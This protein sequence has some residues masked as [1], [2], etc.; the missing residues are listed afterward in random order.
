MIVLSTYDLATEVKFHQFDSAWAG[1][2]DI[3]GELL[4]AIQKKN[5]EHIIVA[6]ECYTGTRNEE[7]VAELLPLLP[8]E[9]AVIADVWALNNEEE[10][11]TVHY[12]LTDNRVFCFM[13]HYEGCEFSPSDKLGG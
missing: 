5:N 7:I 3:A 9:K 2:K 10:T 8:V 4:T 1:Y 13:S 11:S 12:N 6:I